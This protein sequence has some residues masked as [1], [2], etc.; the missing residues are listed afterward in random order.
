MIYKNMKK[1]KLIS[2]IFISIM[3]ISCSKDKETNLTINFSHSINNT[4]LIIGTGCSNGGECLPD[5]SCCMGGSLLPYI[6]TAGESY[7]IQR[8]NYLISDITLHLNDGNEK[9]LQEIYFVDAEDQS[10]LRFDAGKLNDGNYTSISFTMG[11]NQSANLSNAYVNE[12]F[13]SSMAWP[14]LMGGGYHYMKIEGDY[15]TITQGYATHTGPTMGIDYSF[16]YNQDINLFVDKDLGNVCININMDI[17]NWYNNPNT[18]N[19]SSGIMGDMTKQMQLQENG[20]T[21]V[22]SVSI[23]E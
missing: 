6:N 16:P 5:H 12:S 11:L 4:D 17:N 23:N 19:L 2:V 21:D 3:L 22:F 9:K 14:E 7:N 13:H 18:I 1:Y 8:L 10:T 15:D 20:I